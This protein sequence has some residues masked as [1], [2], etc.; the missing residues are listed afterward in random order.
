MIKNKSES[1]KRTENDQKIKTESD[2][3]KPKNDLKQIR[4]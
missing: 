1:N 3:M 4:K 2:K